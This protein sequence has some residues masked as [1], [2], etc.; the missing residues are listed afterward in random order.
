MPTETYFR[1]QRTAFNKNM[2]NLNAAMIKGQREVMQEL[3]SILENGFNKIVRRWSDESRPTFKS[4]V[5]YRS[6]T[7]RFFVYCR[8]TG[9]ALQVGRFKNVDEGLTRHKKAAVG[10]NGEP[11]SIP[12][13][14]RVKGI[15]YPYKEVIRIPAGGL[16]ERRTSDEYKLI[17]GKAVL[18]ARAES[19]QEYSKYV[20]KTKESFKVRIGPRGQAIGKFKKDKRMPVGRRYSPYTGK[21]GLVSGPGK[22]FPEKKQPGGLAWK[23]IEYAYEVQIGDIEARY[24]TAGLG[25][26]METGQDRVGVGHLWPGINDFGYWVAKGYRRGTKYAENT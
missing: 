8:V 6:D 20:K 2:K 17:A 26:L 18:V 11:T 9:T 24:F 23:S 10:L 25:V 4:Q 3:G 14:V 1:W 21:G 19:P 13:K 5:V 16:R 12:N 7:R 15:E 22:Y